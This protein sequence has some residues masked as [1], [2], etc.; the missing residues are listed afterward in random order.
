MTSIVIYKFSCTLDKTVDYIEDMV[1]GN[2]S[3]VSGDNI[4]QLLKCC[5][6]A[7]TQFIFKVIPEVEIYIQHLDLGCG[8][9][10]DSLFHD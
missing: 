2:D 5:Q 8:V 4:S 10:E 3:D 7:T 1:Q 6:L 9:P